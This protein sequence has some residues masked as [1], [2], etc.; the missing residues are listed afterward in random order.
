MKLNV[1]CGRQVLEGWTNI[2]VAPSPETKKVPDLLA[3]ATQ[4]PLA[5]GCADVLMVIH[6]FEH[7]YRWECDVAL[8][9]WKRL[10]RSGGQLILELPDLFRCCQNV[11]NG[12]TIF[13]RDPE[14]YGMWGLYGDPRLNDP[15]MVHR[16][17]WT[18]KT[19]RKI[20][21]EHGYTNITDRETQWHPA[22]RVNRDMR[23]EAT[24]P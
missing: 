4:I 8:D 5:D 2:D 15:H 24:K 17:G 18:P 12:Y 19:L 21:Q 7:L 20:L 13:G 16:W 9:E 3:P 10:L 6:G 11:L 23:I 1:C 22:G 14:Q